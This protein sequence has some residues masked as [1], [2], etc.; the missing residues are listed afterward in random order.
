MKK[1]IV[2]YYY[3]LHCDNTM[4]KE[5]Y[6]IIPAMTGAIDEYN[7]NI[8][9]DIKNVIENLQSKHDGFIGNRKDQ[10]TSANAEGF[11]KGLAWAIDSIKMIE[12][13]LN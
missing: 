11:K 1:E 7:Q 6:W 3:S 13:K 2:E 9:K 12:N 10:I 4:D 8:L 5:K